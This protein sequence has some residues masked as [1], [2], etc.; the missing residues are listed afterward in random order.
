MKTLLE[1]AAN[2]EPLRPRERRLLAVV[3]IGLTVAILASSGF[4]NWKESTRALE[5]KPCSICRV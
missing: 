2:S 4:K 5:G 1:V 3:I